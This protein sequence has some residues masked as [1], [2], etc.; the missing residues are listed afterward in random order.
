MQKRNLNSTKL[1]TS[2]PLAT[3][4]GV[5]LSQEPLNAETNTLFSLLLPTSDIHKYYSDQTG[6][7]PVQYSRGYQYVFI[8]YEY[9]RNAILAKPL[10]TRQAL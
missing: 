8:L 5:Q 9:N 2:V 6:K 1:R 4:I 10:K 7:F 3:S